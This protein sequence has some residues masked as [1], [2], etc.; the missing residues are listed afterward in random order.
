MEANGLPEANGICHTKFQSAVQN[1]IF[2]KPRVFDSA[3]ISTDLNM[4]CYSCA[5]S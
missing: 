5:V 1:L 2:L 3:Y 4:A